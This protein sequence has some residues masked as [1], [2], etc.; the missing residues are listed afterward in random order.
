MI[1][2]TGLHRPAESAKPA[3]YGLPVRPKSWSLSILQMGRL[4]V[5]YTMLYKVNNEFVNLVFNF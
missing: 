1:G 4:Y 2:R 5:V 3:G